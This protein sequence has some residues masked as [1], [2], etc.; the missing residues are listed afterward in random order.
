ML[1]HVE[2]AGVHSGDAAMAIPHT[3]E[4]S[5]IEKVRRQLIHLQKH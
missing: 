4:S 5:M 3:L 2:F 1:Q